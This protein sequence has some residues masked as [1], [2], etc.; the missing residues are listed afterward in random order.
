M[1]MNVLN[2]MNQQNNFFKSYGVI[3]A[4]E[5]YSVLGLPFPKVFICNTNR[6]DQTV[7]DNGGH[8]IC[9]YGTKNKQYEIFDSF[10]FSLNSYEKDISFLNTLNPVENCIRHQPFNSDKC[11]KYVLYYIH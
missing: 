5:I 9:I 10:G 3:S 11:G 1:L 4:N 2:Y 7:N 6:N 8:W